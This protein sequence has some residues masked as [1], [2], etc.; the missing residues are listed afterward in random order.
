MEGNPPPGGV[1]GVAGEEHNEE[2]EENEEEAWS[3]GEDGPS[4]GVD[5]GRPANPP[6]EL[7]SIL[8]DVLDDW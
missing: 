2:K 1:E 5:A 7:A 6:P 4:P 8:L 3:P